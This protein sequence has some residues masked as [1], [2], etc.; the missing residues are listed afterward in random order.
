MKKLLFLCFLLVLLS[1]FLMI[2]QDQE[3]MPQAQKARVIVDQARIYLESNPYSF[4]LDTVTRGTVVT[5]F[6]TGKKSKK[7]LYISYYSD[8]RMAQVTGFIDNKL[9]EIIEEKPV[10]IDNSVIG[11]GDE[12]GIMNI[13]KIDQINDEFREYTFR[14]TD[15]V[16][17]GENLNRIFFVNNNTDRIVEYTG[18]VIEDVSVREG[19]SPKHLVQEGQDSIIDIDGVEIRRDTNEYDNVIKGVKLELLGESE[20]GVELTIDRDYEK[21]TQK[22]VDMIQKYNDLMEY[23]NEQ[24]R[25]VPGRNLSEKNEVGILSGDIT[26]M[27]LKSKLQTIMMNP[28]PTD[29]GKELGL[30][31]QIGI[32]MGSL[33]SNWED[34]KEGYLQVDEDSFIEAFE[35]YPD[36]IKQLFGSDTNNDVVIDNGVAYVMD[37]T[38]KAYIAPR[39]GIITN[40]VNRTENGIREQEDRI[41]DWE[42]HLEDYRKKLEGDFTL[43]QQAL[44]EL[45]QSQKS[46]DNFSKQ[47]NN[48]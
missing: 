48:K 15:I 20:Q 37:T 19:F 4:V 22:I 17:E 39:S 5:L 38:M 30:L 43:M 13:V 10:I 25:I 3:E 29:R 14:I 1:P 16:P 41:D 32:S 33:G 12:R 9:V 6:E 7:W 23:I 42:E 26:V 45:E 21:I 11:L 31:A 27:G 36:T 44:H 24:T 28:Y 2:A 35:K 34:I 8:K 40:R 46:I 18:V 47:L